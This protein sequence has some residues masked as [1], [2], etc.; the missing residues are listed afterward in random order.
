[1]IHGLKGM[2]QFFVTICWL[3]GLLQRLMVIISYNIQISKILFCSSRL[4][5]WITDMFGILESFKSL[6]R[7]YF[8]WLVR[9]YWY[10]CL[11]HH[12][13][14][15]IIWTKFMQFKAHSHLLGLMRVLIFEQQKCQ[16]IYLMC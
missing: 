6:S 12:D 15:N 14:F 13:Q 9:Q 16:A 7:K 8:K 10:F 1:M 5:A 11:G 3:G 2:N 4:H